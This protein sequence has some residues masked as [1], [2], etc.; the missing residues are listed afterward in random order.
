[1]ALERGR[2]RARAA[3]SPL[4]NGGDGSAGAAGSAGRVRG[5]SRRRRRPEADDLKPGKKRRRAIAGI[6]ATVMAL[7]RA[8][9][10]PPFPSPYLDRGPVF[11]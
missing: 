5:R 7:G 3:A 1:M 8:M 2:T 10:D 11:V 4:V 6:V 9:L